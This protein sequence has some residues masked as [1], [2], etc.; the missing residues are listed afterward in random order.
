MFISLFFNT[1]QGFTSINIVQHEKNCPWIFLYGEIVVTLHSEKAHPVR[2]RKAGS[3]LVRYRS[4]PPSLQVR[5]KSVPYIVD[6]CPTIGSLQ[7]S[8]AGYWA[9]RKRG[10][11]YI[12]KLRQ[13][14]SSTLARLVSFAKTKNREDRCCQNGNTFRNDKKD[15]LIQCSL[16]KRTRFIRGSGFT[17]PGQRREDDDKLSERI[18]LS[19]YGALSMRKSKRF[20]KIWTKK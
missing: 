1:L 9:I 13:T 16:G 4:V 12:F 14:S 2:K 11:Q 8:S 5:F 3:S 17:T 10:N 6:I 15:A 20:S 19:E 7:D 18:V